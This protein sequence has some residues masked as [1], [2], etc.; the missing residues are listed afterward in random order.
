MFSLKIK[1]NII[2]K[3]R[4][5]YIEIMTRYIFNIMNRIHWFKN[6]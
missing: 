6:L 2:A 5:A 3:L 4:S 1:V